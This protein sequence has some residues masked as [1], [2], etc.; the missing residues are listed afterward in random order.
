MIRRPSRPVLIAVIALIAVVTLAGC[1]DGRKR[2][3]VLPA[4]RHTARSVFVVV[5]GRESS[6]AGLSDALHTAWSQVV[7]ARRFP[8]GTVYVN[9]ARND[10]TVADALAQQAPLAVEQRP[11]VVAVWLGEGDDDVGTPAPQFG[12]DLGALLGRLRQD[13][14]TRVLVASPPVAAPGGRYVAEIAGAARRA[15][16]EVVT[17]SAAAWNPRARGSQQT[18]AQAAAADELGRALKG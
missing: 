4:S 5:G 1:A 3:A 2:P 14:A 9:L 10:T 6:G 17:L 12:R 7:F 13:R 11:T 8:T 18:A 15:G 16:A